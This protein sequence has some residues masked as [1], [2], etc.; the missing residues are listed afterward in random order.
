MPDTIKQD[1]ESAAVKVVLNVEKETGLAECEAV[2]PHEFSIPVARISVKDFL[3][4][5][6]SHG[7]LNIYRVT[8]KGEEFICGIIMP[9]G[10]GIFTGQIDENGKPLPDVIID[11]CEVAPRISQKGDKF[12]MRVER[13]KEVALVGELTIFE[14]VVPELVVPHNSVGFDAVGAGATY[15]N[16]GGASWSHTPVSVTNGFL[17][18]NGAHVNVGVTD[19]VMTATYDSVAWTLIDTIGYAVTGG[20]GEVTATG[21]IYSTTGTKT[22]AIT[23]SIASY[24]HANSLSWTNVKQ[25]AP[26]SSTVKNT[27]TSTTIGAGSITVP[28]NGAAFDIAG[29]ETTT[30]MTGSHTEDSKA[31]GFST[32]FYWGAIQ[33]TL[34][35]GAQSLQWTIGSSPWGHIIVAL[36]EETAGGAARFN[37]LLLLGVS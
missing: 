20:R 6:E 23:F 17:N 28:S 30:S 14:G 1:K 4:D 9:D 37:H 24:G 33:H 5:G 19:G 31:P 35:S 15:A 29:C 26:V 13:V 12:I 2:S 11:Y 18:I 16:A 21:K 25:S 27:G 22:A 32:N 10:P 36:D 34:S 8:D 7:E 3:K